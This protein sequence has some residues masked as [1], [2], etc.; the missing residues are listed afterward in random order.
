ML[1]KQERLAYFILGVCVKKN[2]QHNHIM[3]KLLS[4]V[5]EM[6]Q[7]KDKLCLLQAYNPKIYESFD[8]YERYLQKKIKIDTNYYSSITSSLNISSNYSSKNLVDLY[9]SYT[10]YL[11]GSRIRDEEYYQKYILSRLSIFNEKIILISDFNK[12]IAYCIYNQEEDVIKI[13]EFVYD[14]NS[15]L[16]T[17]ISKITNYFANKKII[18]TTDITANIIGDVEI[19][20]NMLTNFEINKDIS[21]INECY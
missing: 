11:N 20:S 1:E 9:K 16:E 6:D 19:V 15:N 10:K 21:F 4:T 13:N 2:Y 14:K 18:I 17:I 12:N 5:L 7:Y 8:F 3:K